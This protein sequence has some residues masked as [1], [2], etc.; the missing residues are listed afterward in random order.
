MNTSTAGR[1]TRETRGHIMLIGLDRVAKRNAFD[2][3]MLVDL[4]LAMGEYERDENARCALLFAHGEHF[5]GGLDLASVSELFRNGWELPRGAIDL[6]GTFGGPRLS[7]PLIVAVQGYCFTIGIELMLAADISLCAS[8]TRFAQMEVQRGILPFAGA[9]LR[10]PHVA[11]WGNAM[12]WLLTG[13]EFDAA[14]AYRIGLTQEVVAS[15]DLLPRAIWLTERVAAQAPLGIQ[16]T[17]A[18]ARQAF[19]QGTDIAARSLKPLARQLLSSEDAAEGLL[20]MQERRPG[21]FRGC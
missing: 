5:T 8:N 16:A 2:E 13:D 1:V 20:A 3:A 12:R 7:K 18:T 21:N 6:W 14:E 11:G 4:V 10:L 17:L 15:E 9:T 19:S